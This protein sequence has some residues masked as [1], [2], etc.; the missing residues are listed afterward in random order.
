[1]QLLPMHRLIASAITMCVNN[2][3]SIGLKVTSKNLEEN[4]TRAARDTMNHHII[5]CNSPTLHYDKSNASRHN[6]LGIMHK[7]LFMSVLCTHNQ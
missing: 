1:M 2:M 3:A 7:T 6:A 5:T 4:K